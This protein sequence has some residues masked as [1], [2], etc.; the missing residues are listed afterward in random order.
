M[1]ID[2]LDIQNFKRFEA[3]RLELHPQFTLLVGDNGVGKTSLLDALA[4][5]A[6]VW[7]VKPPDSTLV[8]SGRNIAPNDIRLAAV[9]EGDRAQFVECKPVIVDAQGIIA[10]RPVSWR[11]QIREGGTRTTNADATQ[12][13]EIIESVL[14]RGSDGEKI[15]C[16][17]ISYYGAGRA[18]L[19]S[20]ERSGKVKLNGPARRWEAFYDCFDERIRIGDLH[21]WFHREVIAY[22][23]R[24]AKWRPGYEVVK[25]AILQCVPDGNDLWYDGDRTELVVS[26]AGNAQPFG[27]LSAGQRMMVALVADI[28]IKAVTQNAFLLPPDE[29]GPEDEPLPRLLRETPGVVL[30][31]EL[32][33]HLHPK[34]Q[35][36]V[37]QDLTSIFPAI[38]FVATTHSPQTIGEVPREQI[39]LLTDQGIQQPSVAYGAD[40]NWI[41]DHVMGEATSRDPDIQA[42]LDRIEDDLENGL[43]D[44]AEAKLKEVRKRVQ[45]EDGE[46]IRLQSSLESLRLLGE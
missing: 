6:G 25:R 10:D 14:R 29:L 13:L 19:P 46:I 8:N 26:I 12:A 36:R 35:R 45:G 34:W 43:L 16:P 38:Q 28:A 20:R 39:R 5:A 44:D 37:V 7:L 11:R 3:Q 17:V 1:R 32:D 30:I 24:G 33:V 18:W 22:V 41:L 9:R 4:V 40:S 21:K 23:N 15:V 2:R 42:L 31:D 27:N